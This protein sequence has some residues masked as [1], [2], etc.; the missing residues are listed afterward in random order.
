MVDKV[1]FVD[2]DGN[3]YTVPLDEVPNDVLEDLALSSRAARVELFRRGVK[4]SRT[5]EGG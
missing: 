5:G 1:T 4:S 3:P 2:K